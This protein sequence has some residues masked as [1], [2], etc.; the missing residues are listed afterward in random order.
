MGRAY[1]YNTEVYCVYPKYE[2]DHYSPY[3]VRFGKTGEECDDSVLIESGSFS[4][5]IHFSDVHY[6]E[7]KA[8][9]SAIEKN[10]KVLERLERVKNAIIAQNA[11]LGSKQA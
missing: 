5:F 10:T 8:N 1:K 4:K 3:I 11:E 2:G 9:E 6:S 7:E